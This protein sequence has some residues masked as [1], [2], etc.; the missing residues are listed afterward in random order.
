MMLHQKSRKAEKRKEHVKSRKRVPHFKNWLSQKSHRLS[1]LW[2][3][4]NRITPD[5]QVREF[6][7]DQLCKLKKPFACFRD[8]VRE[9]Y[10][11]VHMDQSRLDAMTALYLRC[12]GYT[13]DTVDQELIRH[14]PRPTTEAE[15]SDSL[16]RRTRILQYAYGTAGDIDIAV[17]RPT[18]KSCG[19]SLP[20]WRLGYRNSASHM[21]SDCG[22]YCGLAVRQPRTSPI[23]TTSAKIWP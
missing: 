4:R 1:Q 17:F 14:S 18:G 6:R 5:M 21:N 7:F 11:D 3:F 2:R 19:K 8:M 23:W 9:K 12:A 15:R 16:E 20:T 13:M 10:A 22:L